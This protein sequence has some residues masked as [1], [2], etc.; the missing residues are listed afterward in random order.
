MERNNCIAL[1]KN[2]GFVR[3]DLESLHIF[4]IIVKYIYIVIMDEKKMR[5]YVLDGDGMKRLFL[6]FFRI[7]ICV[8]SIHGMNF[9]LQEMGEVLYVG[10]NGYTVVLSAILGLPGIIGLY[11]LMY[12]L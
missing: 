1:S 6:F 8:L 4:S 10:I 7:I 12:L 2:E 5:D 11:V 9:I 3:L